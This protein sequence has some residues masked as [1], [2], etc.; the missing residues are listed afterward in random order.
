MHANDTVMSVY[1][2]CTAPIVRQHCQGDCLQ[3]TANV[4]QFQKAPANT[5]SLHTTKHVQI[6]LDDIWHCCIYHVVNHEFVLNQLM[7]SNLQLTPPP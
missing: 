7:V 2:L 1:L 4:V 3:A 5:R 6:A